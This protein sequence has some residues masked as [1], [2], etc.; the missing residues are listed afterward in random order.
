M[1]ELAELPNIGKTVEEQLNQ[2]GIFT[3]EELKAAGA[4]KAWL[5]IQEI[6]ESACIHRLLALEG[7]IRGVKKSDLPASVKEELKEFYEEHKLT[8]AFGKASK[9]TAGRSFADCPTGDLKQ[10]PGVGANM[11]QHLKNI[12]IGSVEDLRG[13]D[14]EALYELDCL[15]KGFA[16]DKCV[17]YVFRCA[18]YFAE[19]ERHEPELLKWW[20]WKDKEYKNRTDDV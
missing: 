8:G 13:K 15:K 4:R 3:E 11:E 20:Y 9:R 17:L 1:G 5:G 16:D 18:V 14:P 10:I 6:D 12:G 19:H 2:A 7:A